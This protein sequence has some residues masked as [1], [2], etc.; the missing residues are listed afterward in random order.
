VYCECEEIARLESDTLTTC[1]DRFL[2]ILCNIEMHV[3]FT[4]C[5]T[6]RQ[7]SAAPSRI[8]SEYLLVR[9][10]RAYYVQLTP[11]K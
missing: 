5:F 11:L 10:G 6:W 9:K 1:D 4:V 7:V 8:L 3:C 2:T